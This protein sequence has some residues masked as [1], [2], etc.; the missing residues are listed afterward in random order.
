[1]RKSEIAEASRQLTGREK[2]MFLNPTNAIKID[3]ATEGGDLVVTPTG[4]VLVKHTNDTAKEDS[5]KEYNSI[6]IET[7]EGEKYVSGSAPLIESFLNIFNSME[8]EE[9]EY[10]VQFSRVASKQRAGKYFLFCSII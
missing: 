1:M 7:K 8:S 10:Q 5:D 3:E 6:V 2:L 9:E 4:Y